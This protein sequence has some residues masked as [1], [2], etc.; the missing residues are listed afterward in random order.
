MSAS[1]IWNRYI[2]YVG[3]GAVAMGGVITIIRSL[4]TMLRSFKLGVEQFTATKKQ[5]AGS[6]PVTEDRLDSD[7]SGKIVIGGVLTI[8]LILALPAIQ[9]LL[10][11]RLRARRVLA[12]VRK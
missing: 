10:R 2:R 5:A 4:P 6:A 1:E 12:E 11:R 3:A 7:L 8:V 9:E